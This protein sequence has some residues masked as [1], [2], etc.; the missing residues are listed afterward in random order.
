[1]RLVAMIWVTAITFLGISAATIEA[2][3]G[4]R[5]RKERSHAD[6]AI[7]L[8]FTLLHSALINWLIWSKP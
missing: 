8:L 2:C 4:P 1:M 3:R 6:L 5:P 7:T